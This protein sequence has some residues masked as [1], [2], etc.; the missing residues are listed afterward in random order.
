[1][2]V[3]DKDTCDK[4]FVSIND[5]SEQLSPTTT[6]LQ[7][8]IDT[9]QKYPKSLKFTASVN[10]TDEKLFTRVNAQYIFRQC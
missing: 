10:N 4:I 3:G 7:V 8:V 1:M 5:T 9:G 2:I 6:F